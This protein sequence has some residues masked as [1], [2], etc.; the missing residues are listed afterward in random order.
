MKIY[1][2]I[3]KNMVSSSEFIDVSSLK[4][5]NFKIIY[6][7]LKQKQLPDQTMY[8][9]SRL[10]AVTVVEF[11]DGKVFQLKNGQWLPARWH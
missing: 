11:E 7:D 2:R 6:V 9:D 8:K 5:D 4:K 1:E 10:R 3:Q